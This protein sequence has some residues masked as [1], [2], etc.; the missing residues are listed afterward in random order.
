MKLHY[1]KHINDPIMEL[2]DDMMNLV[3]DSARLGDYVPFILFCLLIVVICV[4]IS[5]IIVDVVNWFDKR[6]DK[7]CRLFNNLIDMFKEV[8]FDSISMGIPG[9]FLVIFFVLFMIVLS[10]III[11][12]ELFNDNESLKETPVEESTVNPLQ[13]A[14]EDNT[15]ITPYL[16]LENI[17]HLHSEYHMTML[18]FACREDICNDNFEKLLK[19]TVEMWPQGVYERKFNVLEIACLN[20]RYEKVKMVLNVYEPGRDIT[21]YFSYIVDKR[22][23]A[24]IYELIKEKK[25]KIDMERIFTG[26]WVV[27]DEIYEF[28]YENGYYSP[29]ETNDTLLHLICKETNNCDFLRF[30][31]SKGLDVDAKNSDGLTPLYYAIKS[32]S[33]FEFIKIL[34]DNGA[35]LDDIDESAFE[36]LYNKEMILQFELYKAK[37]ALLKSTDENVYK[38]LVIYELNEKIK[39]LSK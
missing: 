29:N 21:H 2:I 22:V 9:I 1:M 16:T 10:P 8:F 25:L 18:A 32:N 11:Y 3:A 34:L 39:Q 23:P 31:I 36:N 20:S 4:L 14:I 26:F 38:D 17:K 13:Q 12:E 30:L 15:D 6:W 35:E 28:V 33:S 5:L 37:R 7:I 27:P 19:A 24:E